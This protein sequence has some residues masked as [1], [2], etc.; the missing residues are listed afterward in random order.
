MTKTFWG[1]MPAYRYLENYM[2]QKHPGPLILSGKQGLGKRM[3]AFSLAASLLNCSEDELLQN[4]DF[5]LIDN[6]NESIKV[7]DVLELL[8]QSN[9]AALGSIRVYLVCHAEK[10][11]IQAQNKLLKLLEDRNTRNIVIFICE[12][13]TMLDTIKSRCMTI[14]FFPLTY[15]E[16]EEYLNRCKIE[17]DHAFLINL[18]DNCPYR[19]EDALSVYPR[20]KSVFQDILSISQKEELLSIFHLI[21][22]KDSME[23]Y[24]AYTEHYSMALLMLQYLFFNL[25]LVQ[26]KDALPNEVSVYSNLA[27]LYSVKDTHAICVA[28]ANHQ[29][30][31]QSRIYTKNDFFDL[32]RVMI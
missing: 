7:E 28:I 11:N 4:R 6:G 3:A 21:K 12:Q 31:W 10:M 17:K 32:V 1:N 29:R 16:M 20:L 18:C 15:S 13:N 26:L 30:Q 24:S 8:E 23:F 25:L 5:L 2:K 14:D 22:E 9:L 27:S 19:L